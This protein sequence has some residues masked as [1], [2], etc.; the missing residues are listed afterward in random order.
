MSAVFESDPALVRAI[1][2]RLAEQTARGALHATILAGLTGEE[3]AAALMI[4]FAL[5]AGREAAA[6]LVFEMP[7]S[8]NDSAEHMA[9][10]AD[11]VS[12]MREKRLVVPTSR[13]DFTCPYL[14]E[15]G[16]ACP[17]ASTIKRAHLAKRLPQK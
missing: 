2:D 7:L 16:R 11:T 1:S 4:E 6:G 15:L 12:R 13:R 17:L 8:R 9:L 3:R 10:N 5:R 14:T